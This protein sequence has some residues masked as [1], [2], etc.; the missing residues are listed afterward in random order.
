MKEKI[1]AWFKAELSDYFNQHGKYPMGHKSK[2][3]VDAVY[4]KIEEADIWIP[5][6][7]VY[8]QFNSKKMK[9][10]HQLEKAKNPQ[11]IFYLDVTD[12]ANSCMSI[13]LE[14]VKII[15]AGTTVYCN[16]SLGKESRI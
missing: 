10:I 13:V 8:K 9:M 14:G 15:Q 5:Y 2:V 11:K 1:T 6:G 4:R 12:P 16:A 3:V 7:E